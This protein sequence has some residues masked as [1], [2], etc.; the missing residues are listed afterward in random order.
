MSQHIIK[1]KTKDGIKVQVQ[2]GWDSPMQWYYC[3][4]TPFLENNEEDDPLYSNLY[5]A[6][7][8]ILTLKYYAEVLR[9]R[10]EITLP[11]EMLEA[12]ELD[13]KDGRMNNRVFYEK[14]KT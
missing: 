7:P 9:T 5:E 4:V 13:R 3:V 1:T 14:Q 6:D 2:M 11:A 8:E 12:I 10:F